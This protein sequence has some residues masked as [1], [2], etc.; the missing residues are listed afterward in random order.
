[1][2]KTLLILS[3]TIL[4]GVIANNTRINNVS[5]IAKPEMAISQLPTNG[6]KENL[7]SKMSFKQ[8]SSTATYMRDDDADYALTG[9]MTLA[10]HFDPVNSTDRTVKIQARRYKDDGV[11]LTSSGINTTFQTKGIWTYTTFT[12]QPGSYVSLYKIDIKDLEYSAIMLY[13]GNDEPLNAFYSADLPTEENQDLTAPKIEGPD[14]IKVG[15]HNKKTA[16]DILTLFTAVD[17]VDGNVAC[18]I[19]KD[20]GY[21][22]A[23]DENKFG[24]Y[25]LEIC[26]IDSSRNIA[27]KNVEIDFYDDT[28]E[29]LPKITGPALIYKSDNI[30]LTLEDIKGLYTAEDINGK[31]VEVV[32]ENINYLKSANKVGSY[33]V[34]IIATDSEERTKELTVSVRVAEGLKDMW[35]VDPLEIHTTQYSTLTIE[36]IVNEYGRF[37]GID[38]YN[39]ELQ[40]DH[41][42]DF[43]DIP[44]TY[45]VRVLI[46]TGEGISTLNIKVH[47]EEH[48]V[49]VESKP[50][51]WLDHIGSFFKMIWDW[52]CGLFH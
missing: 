28:E 13:E 45:N 38:V 43:V 15:L 31:S 3:S 18:T 11:T 46:S 17:D 27:I 19:R 29:F 5:V 30:L 44:G 21:F 8:T 12:L 9:T 6:T 49:L 1:M 47:V 50:R 41:Y 42:S 24:I 35:Y 25:T 36:Q 20:T 2:L 33:K 34:K 14:K 32:V 4:S 48:S 10:V 51:T 22:L 40:E 37:K 23:V 26:S 52:I 7:L 39:F 16:D